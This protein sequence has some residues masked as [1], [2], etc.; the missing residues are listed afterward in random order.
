MN[1]ILLK[2]KPVYCSSLVKY[3]WYFKS[4]GHEMHYEPILPFGGVDIIIHLKDTMSI[5]RPH[6]VEKE[7]QIFIEGQYTHPVYKKPAAET[8]FIGISLNPYSTWALLKTPASEFTG[9]V[10]PIEALHSELYEALAAIASTNESYSEKF[11]QLDQLLGAYQFDTRA[12]FDKDIISWFE[13]E[14]GDIQNCRFSERYFQ[15]RFKELFGV[16][17]REMKSKLKFQKALKGL[18]NQECDSLTQLASMYGYYDQAHFNRKFKKYT[19][20]SPTR[21]LNDQAELKKLCLL[22]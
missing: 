21:F 5:R 15:Y 22:V 14:D 17:F 16:S 2:S 1:S 8:E 10:V 19:D 4:T 7:P 20:T 13:H 18:V 6:G 3:F 12:A 11:M 9:N